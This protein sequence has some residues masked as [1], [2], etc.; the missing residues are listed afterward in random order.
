[1]SDFTDRMQAELD[2]ET[3]GRVSGSGGGEFFDAT[4]ALLAIPRGAADAVRNVYDLGD[5]VLFDALPDWAPHP[6]GQSDST[7]GG[8]IEGATDFAAGFIPAFGQLSKLGYF[9]DVATLGK[10]AQGALAS[11][12]AGGTVMDGHESRL[13]NLLQQSDALSNPITEF[14]AAKEGDSFFEGRVK[15][16]LENAGLGAVGDSL[17][18]GLKGL[19]A[20]RAVREA[21][22]SPEAAAEAGAKAATDAGL[23]P[24]I[25]KGEDPVSPTSPAEI[26][27]SADALPEAAPKAVDGAGV[28]GAT[29]QTTSADLAKGLDIPNL[30][31]PDAAAVESMRGP[32]GM[33][34]DLTGKRTVLLRNLGLNQAQ[35]D[36]FMTTW[37]QRQDLT[38]AAKQVPATETTAV[39]PR[40]LTPSERMQLLLKRI[41][42]NLSHFTGQEGAAEL[43]RTIDELFGSSIKEDM[44]LAPTT[45][46]EMVAKSNALLGEIAK[47]TGADPSS[48]YFQA[49]LLRRGGELLTHADEIHSH[50]LAV[51]TALQMKAEYLFKLM[52]QRA[53]MEAGSAESKLLTVRMRQALQDTA[54]LQAV[55]RGFRN[56]W[57]RAGQAMQIRNATLP[58]DMWNMDELTRLASEGMT[59]ED[60]IKVAKKALAAANGDARIA[61]A[62]SRAPLLARFG[63]AT[64]EYWMNALLSGLKTMDVNVLGPVINSVYRP[65]ERMLGAKLVEGASVLKGDAQRAIASN[66]VFQQTVSQASALKDSVAESF[67]VAKRMGLTGE[68]RLDGRVGIKDPGTPA[69]AISS[70]NFDLSSASAMGKMVDFLGSVVNT[71]TAILAAGDEFTKNLNYRAYAKGKFEQDALRAGLTG[72]AVAQHVAGQMDRLVYKDQ[73]Y[74]IQTLFQRGFDEAKAANPGATRDQLV[75]LAGQYVKARWATE[76][77]T[78]SALSKEAIDYARDVTFTTPGQ[79]GSISH[80]LQRLIYQ[81]PVLRFVLP[82]INTPMNLIKWTG[83]RVDFVSAARLAASRVFPESELVGAKALENTKSR[84]ILEMN[85]GDPKKAAD[86]VGR[87]ATG[88]GVVTYMYHKAAAGEITGRGPKDPE[89]RRMLL[90][91][92]WLPYSFKIGNQYVSYARLDPLASMIGT[93]ADIADYARYAHVDEQGKVETMAWGIAYAAANNFTNKT[94]LAGLAMWVDAMEDPQRNMAGFMQRFASSFVPSLAGQAVL[95]VGDENMRD[96]RSILDAIV[97]RTPGLSDTLPPQ[98]NVLGEPV[99]RLKA[100][101]TD[102]VNAWMDWFVPVQTTEVSDDLIKNEMVGLRHAFTTPKPEVN[103]LNLSSITM[104]DGKQT[105][106]DRWGELHGTVKIGGMTL[107][108]AL[109]RTIKSREYQNLSDVTTSDFE[110]PRVQ[111]LNEVIREYRSA[112]WSQVLKESPEVKAHMRDYNT[113]KRMLRAGHDPR[114]IPGGV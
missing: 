43:I 8:F 58:L 56:K 82:F 78:M 84:F 113:T 3:G 103:G 36:D 46:A 26:A 100:A 66:E 108:D 86:A 73:L 45:R 51:Q 95:P 53:T 101:G 39:N 112:A 37:E 33:V 106:Y 30:S 62:I 52:T 5:K 55:T 94:Y 76:G 31:N 77:E 65:V 60:A 44:G 80:G 74:T 38:H 48:P 24:E 63:Q 27:G 97:N 75:G 16:A 40:S 4:D 102:A 109:R 12:I 10:I 96:V 34:E 59:E 49:A 98:R 42:P 21:G 17:L 50:L 7:V 25:L 61:H 87:L 23:T 47:D 6:L 19:R 88:A 79:P 67:G 99:K 64:Q 104:P 14:L 110:S 22:G 70:A 41:D 93:V 11:G 89:Q 114:I 20:A 32:N 1:V 90:D 29:D 81:H 35:I 83:Q 69:R 18:A 68:N 2:Q 107:R 13:S 9:K 91:N 85:S 15:S 72:D 57:G 92:G 54:D 105:V 28:P 111:K 71:P